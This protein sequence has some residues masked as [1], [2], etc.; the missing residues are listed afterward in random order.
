MDM[1]V[2]HQDYYAQFITESTK[3]FILNSLKLEDIKEALDDGDEHLNKI[4][5]PFNNMGSGGGWWWDGS[6][7]NESLARQLGQNMS[8]STHTCVGKACAKLM[9]ENF[10]A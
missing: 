2:S 5:I 3:A 6:P 10:V 7:V 4:K 9:A 1:E 8:A